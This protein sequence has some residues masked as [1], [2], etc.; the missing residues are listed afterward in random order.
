MF[1]LPLNV[2]NGKPVLSCN[3]TELLQT[4][5]NFNG[6]IYGCINKMITTNSGRSLECDK[7]KD[8][9]TI[10]CTNETLIIKEDI[11][12]PD[13][14]YVNET[15][16]KILNCFSGVLPDEIAS[17]IPTESSID[18]TKKPETTGQKVQ[19]F[20][21]WWF[22]KTNNSTRDKTPLPDQFFPHFLNESDILALIPSRIVK[23]NIQQPVTSIV[24]QNQLP[25]SFADVVKRNRTT[26]RP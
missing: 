13:I 16:T 4:Q 20:V 23:D 9:S 1:V 25:L 6:T 2:P 17:S 11:F 14:T 26:S 24:T 5:I 15:N 8:V 18:V 10:Y 12:C 19:Y 3:A 21:R 22:G 7:K